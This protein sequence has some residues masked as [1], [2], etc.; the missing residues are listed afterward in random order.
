MQG[1]QDSSASQPKVRVDPDGFPI[2]QV[3]TQQGARL[4][5]GTHRQLW[6]SVWMTNR[7]LGRKRN[8]REKQ[9]LGVRQAGTGLSR[10]Q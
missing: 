6:D 1:G 10:V 8:F 4:E 3:G 9:P 5:G 7:T 2:L